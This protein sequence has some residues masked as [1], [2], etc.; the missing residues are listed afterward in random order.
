MA[1]VTVKS[2]EKVRRQTESCANK[3]ET[4]WSNCDA[5]RKNKEAELLIHGR[6]VGFTFGIQKN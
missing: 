1:T 3:T 5:K 2:R 4:K 6:T